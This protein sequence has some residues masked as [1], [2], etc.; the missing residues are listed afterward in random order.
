MAT[1]ALESCVR[2]YHVYGERWNPVIGEVLGC[3]GEPGNYRDFYAV[4]IYNDSV[5]AGH[6]P[7]K[8]ARCFSIFLRRGGTISCEITG[9]RKYSRD[10]PQGGLEVPC[11]LTFKGDEKEIKKL[12]KL[13]T[14]K[15]QACKVY[16]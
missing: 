10:L 12:V 3:M 2:G 13:F 1:F 4:A 7:R 8:N 14:V 9:R 5:I 16:S 6:L 15:D 11:V